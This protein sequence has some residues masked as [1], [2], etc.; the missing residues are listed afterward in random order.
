MATESVSE[1]TYRST[2]LPLPPSFIPTERDVVLD[3]LIDV[4]NTT[5]THPDEAVQLVARKALDEVRCIQEQARR[6]LADRRAGL[7][8][9]RLELLIDEIACALRTDADKLKSRRRTQHIAFQRQIAMYLLRRLTTASFPAIGEYFGRYHSTVIYAVA[10][11]ER[12]MERDAAFCQF[13]EELEAQIT[14]QPHLQVYA[15]SEQS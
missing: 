8:A 11:I 5:L 1:S 6:K 14:E 15:N 3:N 12:R 4:L 9:R 10:L 2:Y 13:I 7:S